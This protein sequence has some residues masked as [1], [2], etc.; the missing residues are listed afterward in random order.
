MGNLQSTR[1][2]Y[3]F[4]FASVE[5]KRQNMF[6]FYLMRFLILDSKWNGLDV[7][8]LKHSDFE[9]FCETKIQRPYFAC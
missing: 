3:E 9:N 7:L 1:T 8:R 5:M 2:Q 4:D 6:N